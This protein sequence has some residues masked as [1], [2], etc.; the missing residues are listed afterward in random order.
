MASVTMPKATP[1]IFFSSR[2]ITPPMTTPSRMLAPHS[3]STLA[4]LK[5]VVMMATR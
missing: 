3:S 4:T 5:R 1:V 2:L